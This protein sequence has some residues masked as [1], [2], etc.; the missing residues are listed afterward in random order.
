MAEQN[1][2]NGAKDAFIKQKI[3]GAKDV[4]IKQRIEH[5][6]QFGFTD[7]ALT[8]LNAGYADN[9]LQHNQF[10]AS[11]FTSA[12]SRSHVAVPERKAGELE[13][14]RAIADFAKERKLDLIDAVIKDED[15]KRRD[16][17]LALVVNDLLNAGVYKRKDLASLAEK[18]SA[19][20]P[21]TMGVII[22][23][24]YADYQGAKPEEK[25]DFELDHNKF[26]SLMT[27]AV[28][29]HDIDSVQALIM[30]NGEVPAGMRMNSAEMASFAS[31]AMHDG[32]DRTFTEAQNQIRIIASL[33]DAK[34]LLE[35]GERYDRE[36]RN[37]APSS[38]SISFGVPV[39]R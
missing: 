36:M 4:F 35:S 5:E 10:I 15:Y 17:A 25:K 14:A 8:D 22:R 39:I 6:F 33:T 27:H 24:L 26:S 37:T 19:E 9:T 11:C 38:S 1:I 2:V 32:S 20:N 16:H 12:I 3:E 28:L 18:T 23:K 30:L 7:K 29:A 21:E 13:T 34:E 31:L